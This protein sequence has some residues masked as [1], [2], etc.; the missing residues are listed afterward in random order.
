MTEKYIFESSVLASAC[1]ISND[2][3][4]AVLDDL[5]LLKV[6]EKQDITINGEERTLYYSKPSHNILALLI[7]AKEICYKG[8]Y[9]LKSNCRNTPFI[10]ER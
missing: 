6:I 1:E 4:N 5:Q 2:K 3:I 10:K 9:C 7:M 8:A